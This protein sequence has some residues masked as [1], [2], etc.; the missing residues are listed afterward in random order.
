MK[1]PELELLLKERDT[2]RDTLCKLEALKEEGT[3]LAISKNYSVALG[4]YPLHIF[5]DSEV[6]VITNNLKSKLELL[7][8]KLFNM[9]QN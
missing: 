3:S 9:C 2:V 8:S 4:S 6:E 5:D 7:E 1:K